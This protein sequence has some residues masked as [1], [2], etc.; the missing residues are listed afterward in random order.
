MDVPKATDALQLRTQLLEAVR[1]RGGDVDCEKKFNLGSGLYLTYSLYESVGLFSLQ[2]Y[3]QG[4]FGK[5]LQA[6]GEQLD[7]APIIKDGNAFLVESCIELLLGQMMLNKARAA[8][9]ACDSFLPCRLD[10]KC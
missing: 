10:S 9:A 1:A 2:Q 5:L 8:C 7:L 6:L 3:H 4:N